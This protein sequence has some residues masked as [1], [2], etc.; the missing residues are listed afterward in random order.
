MASAMAC[1]NTVS[2]RKR[3]PAIQSLGGDSTARRPRNAETSNPR[4]Y[5]RLIQSENDVNCSVHLDGLAIEKRRPVLPLANGVNGCLDKK[6]MSGDS[7]HLADGPVLADD[8]MKFDYVL[9]PRV[10]RLVR[11]FWLD[12]LDYICCG[13]LSA[14]T[15]AFHGRLRGRLRFFLGARKTSVQDRRGQ[16]RNKMSSH[17]K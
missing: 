3:A 15:E 1:E 5:L 10:S 17:G 14:L 8:V 11:I 9:Y 6:R 16:K 7:F 13:D 4:K 12:S 2:H